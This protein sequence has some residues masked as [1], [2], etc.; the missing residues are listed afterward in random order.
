MLRHRRHVDQDLAERDGRRFGELALV[1]LVV[2][3]RFLFGDLQLAAEFVALHLAHDELAL[4][5]LAQV[6]ERHAFLLERGL[7]ALV[8]LEVVVLAHVGEPPVELLVG[9]LHA[10]LAAKLGDEELVDRRDQQLRRNLGQRLLQLLVVLEHLRVD[11]AIPQRRDLPLLQIALRDD[12]AVHLD[13]HL[14][15]DLRLR[16]LPGKRARLDGGEHHEGADGG[17]LSGQH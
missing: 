4:D 6:A 5:V 16:A 17:C 11:L 2:L 8:V 15:D 10:F 3:A 14:L 12:V 7:E 9:E 1:R 13:E